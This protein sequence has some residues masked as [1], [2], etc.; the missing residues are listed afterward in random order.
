MSNHNCSSIKVIFKS[1]LSQGFRRWCED[2]RVPD[3]SFYSTL[4]HINDVTKDS[5][6]VRDVEHEDLE[7][8]LAP[9]DKD[10]YVDKLEKR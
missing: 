5:D 8:D 4:I 2:M 7:E 10:H 9:P 1:C 6:D 3:E